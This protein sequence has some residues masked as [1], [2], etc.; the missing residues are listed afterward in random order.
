MTLRR[1]VTGVAAIAMYPFA[2]VC[3]AL[4]EIW[5]GVAQRLDW[6]PRSLTRDI[7]LHASW[8]DDDLVVGQTCGWPLVTALHDRVRVLG[9][10]ASTVPQAV[11]PQYRSVLI[12]RRRAAPSEF[13]GTVAAVNSSDSLSGWVSLLAA[14]HG[15]GATWTGEVR[16]TGAHVES[17]RAVRDGQADI[18][19]I[20]RVSLALVRRAIPELLDGVIE[21]GEGPLVPSLPLVTHRD[22]S[23]DEVAQIRAALGASVAAAPGAAAAA[24]VEAFVPLDLAD[25][26]PLRALAPA[27]T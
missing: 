22:A 18:A 19:S 20:D 9:V 3:D 24:L 12:A 1:P 17:L 14:V 16:W 13:A 23:D 7:D 5:A 21:V 15:P 2:E 8:T 27:T 26:E 4:D 11:G 25:Y 10:F 6:V